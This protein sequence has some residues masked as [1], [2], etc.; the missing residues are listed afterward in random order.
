MCDWLLAAAAGL[1]GRLS[2]PLGRT[3]RP[4]PLAEP[5]VL[6]RKRCARNAFSH[7]LPL[8]SADCSVVARSASVAC[9]AS[10]D[11]NDCSLCSVAAVC[12]ACS[13]RDI[14][15]TC[16]AGSLCNVAAAC[17]TCSLRDIAAA[18]SAGSL[19]SV[20]GVCSTCSPCSAEKEEAGSCD[21]VCERGLRGNRREGRAGGKGHWKDTR[22]QAGRGGG[23]G[24]AHI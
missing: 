13:L 10:V 17:S 23:R 9:G 24:E 16:S 18:C 21:C 22:C 5:L 3:P 6:L 20:A 11:R 12:S 2:E 1:G 4:N 15:A 19:C 14:A 7:P 8:P